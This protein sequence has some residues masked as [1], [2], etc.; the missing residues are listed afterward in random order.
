MRNVDKLTPREIEVM[1]LLC[2]GKTIKEISE[3]LRISKYTTKSHFTHIFD[4]Y[5]L[6]MSSYTIKYVLAAINFIRQQENL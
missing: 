1:T 6:F 3:I 2:E 4:K 5:G